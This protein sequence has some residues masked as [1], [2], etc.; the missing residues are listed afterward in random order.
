MKSRSRFSVLKTPRNR[1]LFLHFEAC[2]K[3][4]ICAREKARIIN[5]SGG[6]VSSGVGKKAGRKS[7]AGRLIDAAASEEARAVRRGPPVS[8]SE[9]SGRAA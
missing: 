7:G 8:Q 3:S 2:K 6:A 1:Y 9:V 4:V 5:R